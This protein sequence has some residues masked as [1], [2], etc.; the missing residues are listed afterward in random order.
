[1]N[2]TLLLR[3]EKASLVKNAIDLKVVKR[4]LHSSL[5]YGMYQ[6][7][8][9][10]HII[11]NMGRFSPQ[12]YRSISTNAN[13]TND[14][15]KEIDLSDTKK[16]ETKV[17]YDGPLTR[18][19]KIIKRV[20]IGSLIGTTC[21]VPFFIWVESRIPMAARTVL[22]VTSVAT[23]SASTIIV[24][25]AMKP[26]ITRIRSVFVKSD[27]NQSGK[28]QEAPDTKS[29]L[30]LVDTMTFTAGTR[31]RIVDPS[32][33]KTSDRPLSTWKVS[34]GGPSEGSDN[35][36]RV[37]GGL[38]GKKRGSSAVTNVGVAKKGDIFFAHTDDIEGM[39]KE[40]KKFLAS[41]GSK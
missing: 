21:A 23:T 26:Y 30:Y 20:S 35:V 4:R 24:T 29:P 5:L 3:L 17:I 34:D 25:W 9:S 27:E 38:E 18:I 14:I 11:S 39:S 6:R 41:I 36:V 15:P 2:S 40:M 37:I 1:M 22:A 33:L 13:N 7:P 10:Q 19:A 32:Q 28:E 16:Y 12:D 8:I 31:T